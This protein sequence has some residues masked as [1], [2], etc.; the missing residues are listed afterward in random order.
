MTTIDTGQIPTEPPPFVPTARPVRRFVVA[1]AILAVVLVLLWWSA[2]LAPRL[3]AVGRQPVPE[4]GTLRF[5][6]HN[7]GP[8]S[9][10][11]RG[12]SFGPPVG[13]DGIEA[14]SVL[15]DGHDVASGAADV[16]SGAS[17]RVDVRV[18][19]DCA[20]LAGPYPPPD[21]SWYITDELA[22]VRV[23]APAGTE[24]TEVVHLAGALNPILA[25][26]CGPRV[27]VAPE[28]P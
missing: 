23:K 22:G 3:S 24:H 21:S 6:L 27:G 28:A 12:V 20:R 2:V 26:A 15:V 10:E 8:S 1:L 19:V 11:V 5:D 17:V 16:P 14:E 13:Y 4:T 25:R 7:D 9:F 18:S